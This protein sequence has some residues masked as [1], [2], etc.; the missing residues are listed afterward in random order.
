[1]STCQSSTCQRQIIV[2][3]TSSWVETINKS[4]LKLLPPISIRKTD[5]KRRSTINAV[6]IVAATYPSYWPFCLKPRQSRDCKKNFSET[7]WSIC[8]AASDRD[9]PSPAWPFSNPC[10][11]FSNVPKWRV[12][13]AL[14]L[15]NLFTGHVL[16]DPLSLL[17]LSDLRGHGE[18]HQQSAVKRGT[19]TTDQHT[20]DSWTRLHTET[21]SSSKSG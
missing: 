3:V 4:I 5:Q 19:N 9:W 16:W 8:S 6:L 21:V 10:W 18:T 17:L 12:I 20:P 2:R 14:V 15:R 11:P 1:M 7:G 13:L